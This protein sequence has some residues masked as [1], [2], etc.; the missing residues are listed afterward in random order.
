LLR[1]RPKASEIGDFDHHLD[2]LVNKD[3]G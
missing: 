1:H 2:D 3:N